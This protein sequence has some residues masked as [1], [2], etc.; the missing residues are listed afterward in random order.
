[1]CRQIPQPSQMRDVEWAT[2]TCP[3]TFATLGVWPEG[4]DG[5]DVNACSR[6]HAGHLMASAD[7][8]GRVKLFACPASQPKVRFVFLFASSSIHFPH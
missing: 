8:F 3:L 2:L 6:S 4:A 7:D 1:M 5:T